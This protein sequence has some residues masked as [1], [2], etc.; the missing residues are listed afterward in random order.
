MFT[1][2]F[3]FGGGVIFRVVVVAYIAYVAFGERDWR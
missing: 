1:S 2:L 3:I